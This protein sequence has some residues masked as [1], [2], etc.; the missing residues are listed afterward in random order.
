[1]IDEEEEEGERSTTHQTEAKP[2]PREIGMDLVYGFR[3]GEVR[4]SRTCLIGLDYASRSVKM[5]NDSLYP[6]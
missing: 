5:S 6:T 2:G 3:S 1:M 4:L